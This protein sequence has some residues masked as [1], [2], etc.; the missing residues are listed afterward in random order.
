VKLTIESTGVIT[1]IAGTEC[2]V[3]RGTTARGTACVVFVHRLA[4]PPGADEAAVFEFEAE[5]RAAL[6]PGE[7]APLGAALQKGRETGH[8]QP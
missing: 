2:R 7:L 3:W 4:L 8:V 1:R 5:L 6:E